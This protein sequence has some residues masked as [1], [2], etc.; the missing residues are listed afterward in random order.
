MSQVALLL[1][2]GSLGL[3]GGMHCIAMCGAA[4]RLAVHGTPR[5]GGSTATA[6]VAVESLRRARSDHAMAIGAG[7]TTPAALRSDLTFHASRLLGYMLLGALV[8][9]G[10]SLLRWGAEA[11]PLLRP[12]WAGLN[13]TLLALGIALLVL[14]RQPRWLDGLG[15][16]VWQSVRALQP[17]RNAALPPAFRPASL[18]LAWAL[19]PCGLLYAALA[20]AM[21]ASDPLGGAA[22]MGA[23]GLGT[24]VN[25]LGAQ[26]L[27][28][29][30]QSRFET[31]MA[32]IEG[33]G[34]RIGGALIA[35]M[36]VA[37]LVALALGQPHPFCR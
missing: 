12:A 19:L 16:R 18:G 6:T 37:A 29:S 10:S 17:A 33:A 32:A 2:A 22:A 30:L 14:G 27:L 3:L 34:V 13:A 15:H 28:T 5:G 21:L 7:P 11:T 25:L 1:T 20:V 9:G 31:R 8:G 24:A 36:A 23:F 35:A 26:A 4:Q